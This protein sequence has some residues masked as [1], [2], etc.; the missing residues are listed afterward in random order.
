MARVGRFDRLTV[1][2]LKQYIFLKIELDRIT[3]ELNE[4]KSNK[5]VS[6]VKASYSEFPFTEHSVSV[7]GCDESAINKIK[8]LN[9]KKFIIQTKIELIED[10]I[11]S[12][13]DSQI[14]QII[15]LKYIKNKSWAE[16]A[17]ILGGN[18][19]RDSVRKM[20]RRFLEKN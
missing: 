19:T 7:Q 9:D 16:V 4:I 11:D 10:F 5:T 2:E 18:N 6:T 15:E 17:K 1:Q 8:R 12:I 3:N 14:R 20:S 13:K